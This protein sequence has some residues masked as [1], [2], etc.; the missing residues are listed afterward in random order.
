VVSD[1][2]QPWYLLFLALTPLFV[3]L[4]FAAKSREENRDFLS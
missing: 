3:W 4:V 1:Q 2:A